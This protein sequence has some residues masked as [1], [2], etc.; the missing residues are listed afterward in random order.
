M[1]ARISIILSILLVAGMLPA[2]A[3]IG[4]GNGEI[5]F[6]FGWMDFDSGFNADTGGRF[7]IR[8]GYH[9]T[10][11]FQLEGQIISASVSGFE[12][13]GYVLQNTTL[14]GF[15]LNGV[16][17]FGSSRTVVPYAAAGVGRVAVLNLAT[18][19]GF[20]FDEYG[21]ALQAAGGVRLFFGKSRRAAVRLELSVLQEETFDTSSTHTSFTAGFTWRLG[22][23]N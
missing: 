8:G 16:F 11:L 17:N 12:R 1:A 6:D 4:R 3:G 7:A 19:P 22:S 5:G 20:G 21:P 13:P 10:N 14:A 2:E 15:L 9:F 23:A 18:V